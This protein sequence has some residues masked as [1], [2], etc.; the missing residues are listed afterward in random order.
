MADNFFHFSR[1]GANGMESHAMVLSGSK[2]YVSRKSG[3][4]AVG[5]R[6]IGLVESELDCGY[7][8]EIVSVSEV[9]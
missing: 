4:R 1:I 5:V 6:M 8:G 3:D 7:S 2:V 9:A